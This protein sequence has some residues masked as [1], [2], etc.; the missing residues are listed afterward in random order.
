M[1]KTG[2]Y[3]FTNP[4]SDFLRK[5]MS[6]RAVATSLLY[7]LLYL[8]LISVLAPY[9]RKFYDAVVFTVFFFLIG[10]VIFF[11]A[12]RRFVTKKKKL[13][14]IIHLKSNYVDF[15]EVDTQGFRIHKTNGTVL[16]FEFRNYALALLVFVDGKEVFYCLEVAYRAHTPDYFLL[17]TVQEEAEELRRALSLPA[18]TERAPIRNTLRD[19]TGIPKSLDLAWDGNHP[20]AEQTDEARFA[21]ARDEE[22]AYWSLPSAK[23]FRVPPK[24]ASEAILFSFSWEDDKGKWMGV[25]AKLLMTA[26]ILF[27]LGILFTGFF[28]GESVLFSIFMVFL[29]ICVLG[30]VWSKNKEIAKYYVDVSGLHVVWNDDMQTLYGYGTCFF[31]KELEGRAKEPVLNV[32]SKGDLVFSAGFG[33]REEELDDLLEALAIGAEKGGNKY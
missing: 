26:A 2:R 13:R 28:S 14:W 21:W 16:P 11:W 31:K 29:C 23:N 30:V 12:M 22:E 6:W 9:F 1:V 4:Q 24:P 32:Y 20:V 8:V 18:F 15:I 5:E 25:I 3:Y 10:P 19:W 27:V 33:G 7:I 17:G